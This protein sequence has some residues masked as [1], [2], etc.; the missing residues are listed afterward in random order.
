MGFEA[1]P[2]TINNPSVEQ[3]SRY[4]SIAQRMNNPATAGS[5]N[6]SDLQF[7]IGVNLGNFN[8]A[9][10]KKATEEINRKRAAGDPAIDPNMYRM[11]ADEARK[12]LSTPEYKDR[13]LRIAEQADLQ[14]QNTKFSNALNLAL[15]A[16]DLASAQGQLRNY[17]QELRALRRPGA[18]PVQGRDPYLE[19]AKQAAQEGGYQESI[20][21]EAAK[22]GI[23]E[24]YQ[25]ELGAAKT[26]AAGQAGA[27]GALAQTAAT[28]R[29]RR[30]LEMMPGIEQ[31]AAQRRGY[32][33]QLAGMSAQENAMIN[34]SMQQAAANEQAMYLAES[35]AAAGLGQAGYL[36]RRAAL[37]GLAE[38]LPE[39]VGS[40]R[41]KR[42]YDTLYNRLWSS[43]M[44]EEQAAKFATAGSGLPLAQRQSGVAPSTSSY[45]G[46]GPSPYNIPGPDFYTPDPRDA[47]YSGSTYQLENKEPFQNY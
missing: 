14:A 44:P 13:V 11:W 26:A 12:K 2:N 23:R 24:A 46:L 16:S 20:A 18:M 5:I 34:Q 32:M 37:A 22:Q 40:Q 43:G 19:A 39:A 25:G 15:S 21:A 3:I 33:G 27:Y 17:R 41:I 29:G 30:T 7:F 47:M 45:T 10:L 42:K 8:E 36:N 4:L 6:D 1:I 35:K 38:G 9:D 28:R 31:I